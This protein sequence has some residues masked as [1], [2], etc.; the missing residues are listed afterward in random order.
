MGVR[1]RVRDKVRV[2]VRVMVSERDRCGTG[3]ACG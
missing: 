2:K 1:E 3:C